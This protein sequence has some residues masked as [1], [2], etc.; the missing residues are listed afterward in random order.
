MLGV[1]PCHAAEWKQSIILGSDPGLELDGCAQVRRLIL[2]IKIA[3]EM[4]LKV[5]SPAHWEEPL[6]F[7][8]YF[9]LLASFYNGR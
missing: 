3:L 1:T 2:S 9:P 6:D 5:W 8:F 4:R 7:C